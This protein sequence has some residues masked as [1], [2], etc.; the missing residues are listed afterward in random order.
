MKDA[1]KFLHFLMKEH[2]V[3]P[4][5]KR[6]NILFHILKQKHK[7]KFNP[8]GDL[9]AGVDNTLKFFADL[10]VLVLNVVALVKQGITWQS[11]VALLSLAS[12]VGAL[13]VDAKNA[14]PE[15]ADLD[16]AESAQIAQ[17]A[18]VCIAAIVAAV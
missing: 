3:L 13:V 10:Q 5:L 15:L 2:W 7:N 8:K 9:M 16:T 12:E 11:I 6:M 4:W 1:M 14:L 17:A 18:Y